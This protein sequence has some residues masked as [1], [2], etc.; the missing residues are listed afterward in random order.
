M[1][2]MQL[3]DIIGKQRELPDFQRKDKVSCKTRGPFIISKRGLHVSKV[4][5]EKHL[6]II[7]LLLQATEV[8]AHL[9]EGKKLQDCLILLA[10][11]Q[12][13]AVALGG[14]IEKLYGINTKTVAI[15][16]Q[17]CECLYQ[18]SVALDDGIQIDAAYEALQ[19]VTKQI[20]EVY[21]EE[22]PD[23]KEVVF[24]P[25]KAAMWDSLES[26]WKAA[27][28]D[29]DCDAYVIP[30]PYYDLDG[31][32]NFK[33][34]HYEGDL[35]PKYV[36]IASYEEYDLEERHPDMIFIHNPYDEYNRVTRIEPKF[37]SSKIKDYTEKLVYIPYFV[38]NEIDP[39][40]DAAIEGMSHFCY[41]PGTM[42]ADQVIVQS[43]DMRTIYI[44]EYLKAAK[45]NGVQVT[46][47]ELEK[48]IL[49]LGSPKLDKAVNTKI[50]D[51]EIPED[52]LRIIEKE[53][54]TWKKIIFYNTSIQS[55]LDNS[56]EMLEKIKDVLR[57]FK[58]NKDDVALLWRPHPLMMQTIESMRPELMDAYK[59]IVQ[60]YRAEGWG[61]YDDSA[62]MDRAI[63]LSDAYYGDWSSLVAVYQ[64]TGKPVMIQDV[65]SDNN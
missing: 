65:K 23:R 13:S 17:Y 32:G 18:M 41:L 42:Y 60:Q 10:D 31:D 24:L 9:I 52:W 47:E 3:S 49:G 19:Q 14:H 58:E 55:F 6:N 26:V 62:D 27:D 29:P 57:I 11:C 28:E 20:E 36:P 39:T 45:R 16:E 1:K 35:Y 2:F 51:L 37:F 22:F 48:R 38:L 21:I 43:E 50:E 30:I 7:E 44:N 54:G 59:E 53:D 12:E 56:E 33:E 40:N 4:V 25:Y 46:R 8:T 15:L 34:M 61:I 64:E 63:V 5:R